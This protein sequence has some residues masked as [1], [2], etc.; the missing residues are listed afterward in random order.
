MVLLGFAGANADP[1]VRQEDGAPAEGNRAH[2]SFSY[3]PHNCPF[4]AQEISEVIATTAIEVLLDRLPDL[5]LAVA[6]H[7]LVWRPSAWVRALVAL[8]VAFTPGYVT[9]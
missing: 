4:P 5:R 1:S 6:E 7:A 8:P 3:G 2:M 9:D